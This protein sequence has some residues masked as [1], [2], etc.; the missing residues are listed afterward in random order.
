MTAGKQNLDVSQSLGPLLQEVVAIATQHE[1]E[2]HTQLA[3]L[4]QLELLHRNI[5]ENYFYPTLPERR[6]DLYNLLRDMEE[7]GGWPYI[8]RP[9]LKLIMQSLME[10]EAEQLENTELE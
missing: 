4:R 5:C 3:I 10:A 9:K 6:R 7:N 8:A 1:G 2:G